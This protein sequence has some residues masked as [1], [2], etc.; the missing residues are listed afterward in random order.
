[1]FFNAGEFPVKLYAFGEYD[2]LIDGEKAGN[3]P[4][5]T[6][7]GD[8]EIAG[9]ST[10]VLCRLRPVDEHSGNNN[11]DNFDYSGFDGNT[12]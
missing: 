6:V 1:V 2:V 5:Y 7:G 11:C 12:P 3:V 8:Y 4:L 9:I 10:L